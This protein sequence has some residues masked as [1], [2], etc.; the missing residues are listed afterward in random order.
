MSGKTPLDYA[1]E[2]MHTYEGL[3]LPSIEGIEVARLLEAA[4]GR[5]K[6]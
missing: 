5:G 1:K 6:R 3:G 2:Y 4:G